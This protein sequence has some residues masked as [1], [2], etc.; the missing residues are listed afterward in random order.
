VINP[1]DCAANEL[2]IKLIGSAAAF[3][4]L[5]A[6]MEDRPPGLSGQTAVSAVA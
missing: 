5:P 2:M 1:F 6:E 4:G 3:P